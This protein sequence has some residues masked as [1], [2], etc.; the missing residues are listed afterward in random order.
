[1]ARARIVGSAFTVWRVGGT[2]IIYCIEVSHRSPQPI[3]GAVDIH[4]LNYIRPAEILTPRSITHGEIVL[5]VVEVYGE[6]IWQNFG[7]YFEDERGNTTETDLADLLNKQLITLTD[8]NGESRISLSRI[9]RVPMGDSP[10]E[11]SVEY[12]ITDFKG[13]RIVD[14]RDD[15]T[16]RTET[17]QNNLQMTVWYTHVER[18][19]FKGSSKGA[20]TSYGHVPNSLSDPAI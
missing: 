13:V 7:T 4:P 5:Q 15:E 19:G 1:M 9:V 2:P 6:R 14:V 11:G 18:H 12:E 17:L 3:T 8:S 16:T 20:G 10:D